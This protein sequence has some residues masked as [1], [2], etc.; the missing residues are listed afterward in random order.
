MPIKYTKGYK[1]QLSETYKVQV[2]IYPNRWLVT[3]YVTLSPEGWLTL[4]KGYASDGA[5]G[6][7][8]DT[9]TI[10][11]GAFCHDGL[12]QIMREVDLSGCGISP[13][14]FRK[15]ADYTLFTMCKEDGMNWVRAEWVY[16]AVRTFAKRASISN[17]DILVAP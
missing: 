5:S 15:Q 10:M 16:L 6:P 9:K 1:Y 17:Q 12:Y 7:A 14:E 13:D 8:I 2:A 4:R 3:D 11:R